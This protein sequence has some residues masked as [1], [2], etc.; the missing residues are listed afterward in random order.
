MNY[1]V[2]TVNLPT[3]LLQNLKYR[4][5]GAGGAIDTAKSAA[6][7]VRLCTGR[8]Y[9]LIVLRLSS[10]NN[11]NEISADLRRTSFA[12][13]V[14][15]SDEYDAGRACAALEN[16]ADLCLPTQSP[17][18]ILTGHIMAQFRRY[19]AYNNF[20]SPLEREEAP[21]TSGDVYIDP[22]RRIVRVKGKTIPLRPR[23]F[24]LLLYFA[25][26]PDIVLSAEQ[27]CEHAWGMEG[28]YNRGISQPIRLLRQAIEPDPERPVYIETVRR[29]GYRFTAHNSETCDEC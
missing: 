3:G 12:P 5:T 29:V 25:K 27:I 7:A 16:G 20:E 1:H 24:S 9:H 26:N 13:I 4:L 6:D 14:I 11:C 15:L 2:L 21:I 17:A 23:E 8:P 28:S 22:M 10:F 18:D 19:T